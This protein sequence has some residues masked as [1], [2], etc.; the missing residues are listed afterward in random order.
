[1]GFGYFER[2]DVEPSYR[3]QCELVKQNPTVWEGIPFKE[4]VTEM[5]KGRKKQ[6]GQNGGVWDNPGVI[7]GRKLFLLQGW[8]ISGRRCLYQRVHPPEQSPGVQQLSERGPQSTGQLCRLVLSFMPVT[9]WCHL[10]RVHLLLTQHLPSPSKTNGL[11]PDTWNHSPVPS[12]HGN[13][14]RVLDLPW[15]FLLP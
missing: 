1:M 13:S 2:L 5:I 9:L 3:N 11:F 10:H 6:K 8:R 7:K 14:H 4:L 15:W 12:V